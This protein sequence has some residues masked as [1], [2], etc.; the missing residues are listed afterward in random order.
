MSDGL[1]KLLQAN[2]ADA[3]ALVQQKYEQLVPGTST[4]IIKDPSTDNYFG[5]HGIPT[6]CVFSFDTKLLWNHCVIRL[7]PLLCLFIPQLQRQW[8]RSALGA[9]TSRRYLLVRCMGMHSKRRLLLLCTIWVRQMGRTLPSR[10]IPA[11]SKSWESRQV[12]RHFFILFSC[13]SFFFPLAA[14]YASRR[15][16]CSVFYSIPTSDFF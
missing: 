3:A 8:F 12:C 2:D 4:T 7:I 13:F 14:Y 6:I 5:G 9:K 10:L 15:L 1:L 16:F 11:T